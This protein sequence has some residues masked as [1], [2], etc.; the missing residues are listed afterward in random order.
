MT[1]P[2]V[3]GRDDIAGPALEAW[4]RGESTGAHAAAEAEA[5]TQQQ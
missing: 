3:Q 1:A 4:I 5:A 2:P